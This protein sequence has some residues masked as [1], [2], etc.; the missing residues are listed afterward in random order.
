MA[1]RHVTANSVPVQLAYLPPPVVAA[2]RAEYCRSANRLRIAD[3]AG[4]TIALFTDGAAYGLLP[5]AP[6][7][8]VNITACEQLPELAQA[9]ERQG[10][11]QIT[12]EVYDQVNREMVYQ[13]RVLI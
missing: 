12:N 10:A 5:T 9:L 7:R 1:T 8:H 13:A 11:I 4:H 6:E 2:F 3:A